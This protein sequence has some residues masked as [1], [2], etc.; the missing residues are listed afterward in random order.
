M[1]RKTPPRVRGAYYHVS[2]SYHDGKAH[3]GTDAAKLAFLDALMRITLA[4]GDALAGFAL[5]SNHVH[6]VFF[7]PERPERVSD[8]ELLEASA[9]MRGENS[10]A[11]REF[12]RCMREPSL[13]PEAR[14]QALARRNDLPE[15]LKTINERFGSFINRATASTG[16]TIDDRAHRSILSPEAVRAVLLYD[17]LNPARAG[18][19]TVPGQYP[20][21]IYAFAK[22][23]YACALECIHRIMG[24]ADHRDS[25]RRFELDL[26][27][28]GQCV[29]P[30][31]RALTPEE[32]LVLIEDRNDCARTHP[33]SDNPRLGQPICPPP[34][35]PKPKGT[36]PS[37]KGPVT[38]ATEGIG[39]TTPTLH[40]YLE[41]GEFIGP[42]EFVLEQA[43]KHWGKANPKRLVL[44]DE[45]AGLYAYS[46]PRPERIARQ[47][48]AE[49]KADAL[50][51]MAE[52]AEARR[53]RESVYEARRKNREDRKAAK[54]ERRQAELASDSGP[55]C[56]GSPPVGDPARGAPAEPRPSPEADPGSHESGCAGSADDT[57]DADDYED[58]L[59][60]AVTARQVFVW[61]Q[62]QEAFFQGRAYDPADL[63]PVLALIIPY[64]WRRSPR[65]GNALEF[66]GRALDRPL[67]AHMPRRAA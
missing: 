11:H 56:S 60:G 12:L 35:R 48:L 10:D 22:R 19:E 40:D 54:R 45:A 21:T 23:G 20:F 28:E 32:A 24:G 50:A 37:A 9:L 7:I 31:K 29:I 30:G 52:E 5:M 3:L 53:L 39:N 63:P 16:R 59:A 18:M 58:D 36:T 61:S 65:R 8:R 51:R 46:K 57:S 42:R 41:R 6:A 33:L 66:R 26:A 15:L 14:R 1:A 25:L 49:A 34:V 27:Q 62:A 17:C 67:L 4:Q 47:R 2:I 55:T 43:A 38:P 64:A 44:I 13:R